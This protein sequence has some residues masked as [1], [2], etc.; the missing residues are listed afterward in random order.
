MMSSSPYRDPEV[1]AI[2]RRIAMPT[3]FVRPARDLVSMITVQP[4][5]RLLDIG[6]GTGALARAAS[7]AVGP[8]GLVVAVDR[9][10]AMLRAADAADGAR[11]AVAAAPG[12]PFANETFDAVGAS[13]VLAHC[14]DYSATL[15]DMVRVCRAGGRLGISAWGSMPNEAG[16]LWKHTAE[17]YVDGQKLHRA[18]SA[19]VPWEDWFAVSGNLEQALAVVGVTA[20]HGATCEYTIE[21]P[22]TDYLTMKKAGVEGSLIRELAGESGWNRFTQEID[23]VFES[24][25]SARVTFVRDVHF[26][27]GTKQTQ[28]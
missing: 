19:S 9:A 16:R 13:F 11:R 14:P 4:G 18:F 20:I 5:T 17:R 12:L 28:V 1:A 21:I 3:Q 27:V 24:R 7:H 8:E 6:S 25:F 23:V 2:Y 26:A 22:P 10:G 15:A